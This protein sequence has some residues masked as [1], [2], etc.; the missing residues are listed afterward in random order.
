MECDGC[1]MSRVHA[2]DNLGHLLHGLDADCEQ[3]T[4]SGDVWGGNKGGCARLAHGVS[5]RGRALSQV[6]GRFTMP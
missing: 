6:P 1:E 2:R 3:G 5:L 4:H